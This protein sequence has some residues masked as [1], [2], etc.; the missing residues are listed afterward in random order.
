MSGFAL[1]QHRRAEVDMRDNS[2]GGLG[3]R[4]LFDGIDTLLQEE[5]MSLLLGGP[6]ET[7]RGLLQ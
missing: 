2:S 7:S 5:N 4:S 3:F 6:P 1:S